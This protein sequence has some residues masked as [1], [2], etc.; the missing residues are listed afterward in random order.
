[1]FRWIQLD[2]TFVCCEGPARTIADEEDAIRY[3]LTVPGVGVMTN[4]IN[5]RKM[6]FC[7]MMILFSLSSGCWISN[8]S[9]RIFAILILKLEAHTGTEGSGGMLTVSAS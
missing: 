4:G 8:A 7:S 6:C 9:D 3:S 5:R 1:M 2:P